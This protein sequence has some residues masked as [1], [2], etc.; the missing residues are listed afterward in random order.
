MPDGSEARLGGRAI[1]VEAAEGGEPSAAHPAA[2]LVHVNRVAVP[3][4]DLAAAAQP[5]KG[6]VLVLG[7]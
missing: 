3:P 5:S 7:A 4:E 6:Q 1:G 2:L